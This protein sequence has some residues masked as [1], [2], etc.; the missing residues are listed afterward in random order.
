MSGFKISVLCHI[1]MC[2][3]HVTDTRI[4]NRVKGNPLL[5]GVSIHISRICSKRGGSNPLH[6]YLRIKPVELSDTFKLLVIM[7]RIRM[8]FSISD[9]LRCNKDI[10]VSS[11]PM[12]SIRDIGQRNALL[13]RFQNDQEM[14][15][16]IT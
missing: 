9:L 3:I 16:D 1:D 11:D 8:L 6:I 13:H 7:H 4:R 5:Q 12:I 10:D 14:H 15:K 2:Q